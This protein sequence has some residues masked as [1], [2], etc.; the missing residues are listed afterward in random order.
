MTTT[1]AELAA[2][3]DA[4]VQA[5]EGVA[6]LYYAAPLPTRL[7]Q[8]VARDETFTAITRRGDTWEAVVSIGVAGDRA[9]EVA[10]RVAARV[11]SLI[12]EAARVTVRVSRL[13]VD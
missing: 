6:Q 7:W 9:D 2:L 11:R 3:V 10:R 1:P 4:E 8:A 12:G 5:I 13:A